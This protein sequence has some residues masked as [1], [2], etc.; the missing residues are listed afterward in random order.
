MK[1]LTP[2]QQHDEVTDATVRIFQATCQND[3]C[4]GG[5]MGLNAEVSQSFDNELQSIFVDRLLDEG[6]QVFGKS[7]IL[8][9]PRCADEKGLPAVA[10]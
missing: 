6:W 2:D 3:K 1:A 9:C 4:G 7:K 10:R 8:L 5:S